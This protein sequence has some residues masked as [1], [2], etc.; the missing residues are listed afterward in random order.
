MF[1]Q[2]AKLSAVSVLVMFINAIACPS[3]AQLPDKY[4]VVMRCERDGD[5]CIVYYCDHEG[6]ECKRI[7]TLHASPFD[8]W[9][10]ASHRSDESYDWYGGP[11]V[12]CEPDGSYCVMNHRPR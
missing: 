4:H 10:R 1:S 6:G 11:I 5:A 2:I 7:R 9:R 12:T 8:S 3:S